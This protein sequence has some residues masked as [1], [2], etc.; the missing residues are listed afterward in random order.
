[1]GVIIII[2]IAVIIFFVIKSRKNKNNTSTEYQ[3]RTASTNQS[4][5]IYHPTP[6]VNRCP[7][8]ALINSPY[9]SQYKTAFDLIWYDGKQPKYK[10]DWLLQSLDMGRELENNG[11]YVVDSMEKDLP[12]FCE[13]EYEYDRFFDSDRPVTLGSID[14]MMGLCNLYFADGLASHPSK[15]QYW[16]QRV[17]ELA[18]SGNLEAQGALCSNSALSGGFSEND[19][20]AFKEKYESTLHSLAESGNAYAQFAVGKYFSPYNSQERKEW[21]TKAANQGLSDAWFELTSVW[22]ATRYVNDE[23][24]FHEASLSEEELRRLYDKIAECYYRGAEAN[25]GVMAAR[26][27]DM[28]GTYYQ[29]GDSI[30]PK[31]IEK[32]KYW[33]QKALENG[34]TSAKYSLDFLNN[35]PELY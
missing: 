31:N 34:E 23:N 35:H 3:Q 7:A 8:D 1:M 28:L 30:F 33:Y 12:Y 18:L 17:R 4:N 2:I 21:L 5:T 13:T 16:Q 32:A 22:R 10:I 25:N 6:G 9:Y 19:V 29:D 24:G 15:L 27:Q 11:T 20:E 14:G 26:C